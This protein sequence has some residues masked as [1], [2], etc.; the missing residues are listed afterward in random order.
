MKKTEN[1]KEKETHLLRLVKLGYAKKLY[2]EYKPSQTQLN[3]LRWFNLHSAT[4]ISQRL[5]V[6]KSYVYA[7]VEKFKKIYTLEELNTHKAR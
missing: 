5:K 3:I 2:V 1:L 4:K 6:D 7:V